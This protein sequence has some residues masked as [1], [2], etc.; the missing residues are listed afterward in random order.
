VRLEKLK[1]GTRGR[2]EA[3]CHSQLGGHDTGYAAAHYRAWIIGR[4]TLL[5]R[6]CGPPFLKAWEDARDGWPDDEKAAA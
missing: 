3:G 5:C 6:H 2:C 4:P 1:R